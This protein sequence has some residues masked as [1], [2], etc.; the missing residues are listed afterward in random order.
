L[1]AKKD[2]WRSSS[3]RPGKA[4][5]VGA[6]QEEGVDVEGDEDTLEAEMTV[7]AA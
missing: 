7:A 3:T 2:F 5:Y 1:I 6:V 4:A